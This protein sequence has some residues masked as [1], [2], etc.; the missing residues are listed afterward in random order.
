MNL[1][2]QRKWANEPFDPERPVVISSIQYE[3]FLMALQ[4]L[5]A[6]VVKTTG[7]QMLVSGTDLQALGAPYFIDL[8][9]EPQHAQIRV[10]VIGLTKGSA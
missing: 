5:A 7:G 9:P 3:R 2:E 1:D 6:I 8:H 4:C 10:T